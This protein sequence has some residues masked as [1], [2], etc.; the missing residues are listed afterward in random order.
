M[1]TG[2]SRGLGLEMV[3]Q[4]QEP[5]MALL[6]LADAYEYDEVLL[7]RLRRVSLLSLAQALFS[8]TPCLLPF[9]QLV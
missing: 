7:T 6:P 9:F 4:L 3:R 5:P 1:I 8:G 2:S